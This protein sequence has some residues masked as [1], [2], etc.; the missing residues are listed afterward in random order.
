MNVLLRDTENDS[1]D[2]DVKELKLAASREEEIGRWRES[3]KRQT[4][5][6]DCWGLVLNLAERFDSLSQK[7]SKL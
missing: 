5:T 4:C 3:G 7:V 6:G 2:S 1:K